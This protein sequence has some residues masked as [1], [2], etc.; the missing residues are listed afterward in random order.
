[1]YSPPFNRMND[2]SDMRSMVA[3]V[4]AA[5]LVSVDA[6]GEPQA[7]LLPVMW[8]G[9]TVI[10]HMAKA[11]RHWTALESGQRVLLI[12]TAH[13]AYISP[14]WYAAK[15]EHGR[16]VP[17]WNYESVHLRGTVELFDSSDEA[18]TAELREAVTDLTDVHEGERSEPW[19]VSDAPDAFIDGQLRGIVGLRISVTTAEGKAKFSQ[20]R[21][22]GDQAGV[23]NGLDVG[24]P[25]D[26]ASAQRMRDVLDGPPS[27][28]VGC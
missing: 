2:D 18:G 4:G 12:V 15:A 27:P 10:A 24:T 13:Q 5:E 20:N 7:T 14:S 25:L 28:E 6:D 19:K 16:V 23:V 11:N 17:T 8:R 9:D 26:Q 21:S 3:A 22:A 1:M